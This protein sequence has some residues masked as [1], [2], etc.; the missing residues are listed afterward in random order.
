MVNSVRNRKT[1]NRKKME[2]QLIIKN[3]QALAETAKK[4]WA[5]CADE[6]KFVFYGN[7][8]AGKTTLIKALCKQKNITQDII[9]S[10]TYSI[11]N[12]Y[13]ANNKYKE[14]IYHIDLYRLQ[15]I[16]E[17]LDL[18][19]EEYLYDENAYCFIEWPQLIE[20]LLENINNIIQ[21][22][23]KT[24]EDENSQRLVTITKIDTINNG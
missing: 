5:I 23:L 11:V 17:A 13:L 21:I 4:I 14:A 10:P 18:G 3:E 19:I 16:E 24:K 1:G 8:G 2:H 15:D 9:S 7:L 6:K 22:H 20:P 12:E